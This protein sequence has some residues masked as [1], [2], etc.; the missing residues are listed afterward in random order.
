MNSAKFF[1]LIRADKRLGITKLTQVQ[2]DCAQL[3]IRAAKAEKL[4]AQAAAYVLATA[5]HE[6]KLTPGRENLNYTTAS[7]IRAVWPTRFKSVDDAKP[8]VRNPK[9]LGNKVYNGRLGNRTGTD[10]GYNFRG[11]GLDQL[12][13]RENYTKIGISNHPEKITEPE[14]AVRSLI[15]GMTTGR[16]RGHK[17]S[18]YFDHERTDFINARE[19][20]NADKN[21]KEGDGRTVAQHVASYA[22]AFLNA[23]LEAGYEDMTNT[24]TA[25]PPVGP[26]AIALIIALLAIA[27]YFLS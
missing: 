13:G 15:H 25:P 14:T 20:V 7:R 6:A 26:G 9:A 19:I 12:T 3:I 1:D 4:S 21:R 27:G 17:L 11:G 5:W 23:L 8:Y 10:D 24:S 22:D 2:V 16:Y 18:Q